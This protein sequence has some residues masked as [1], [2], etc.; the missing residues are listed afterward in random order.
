VTLFLFFTASTSSILVRG[1][2]E[3]FSGIL[4]SFVPKPEV[5][6]SKEQANNAHEEDGEPLRKYMRIQV[7]Q[8]EEKEIA[9]LCEYVI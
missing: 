1:W 9:V 4:P 2:M 8:D 7:L 3:G 5:T 6:K